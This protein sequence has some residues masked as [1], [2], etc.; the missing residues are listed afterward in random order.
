MKEIWDVDYKAI[1][2]DWDDTYQIK[3]MEYATQFGF[4]DDAHMDA[5]TT[6]YEFACQKMME[7]YPIK[8]DDLHNELTQ[9]SRI[10]GNRKK[11]TPEEE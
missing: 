6:A 2:E 1:C 11:G 9:H 7:K 5:A 8:L 10:I 4:S 3:Y